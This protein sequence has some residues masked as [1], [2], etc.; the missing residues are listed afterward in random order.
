MSKPIQLIRPDKLGPGED[1]VSPPG[2][3]WHMLAEGD[4]WFSFGSLFGNSL[5]NKL[6]FDRSTLVTAT[7]KP[8]DTLR[9]MADWWRDA[10]FSALVDGGPQGQRAWK[11]DA[12][13]LSGGGND[14]IDAVSDQ[15]VD[16]Q[17][18]RRFEPGDALP[19]TPA[20]CIHADAWQR[21]EGYLRA[22]FASLS[23]FVANSAKNSAT[24]LFV[25]TYDYPTPN[26]A[27]ALP[28]GKSW[29][30]PAMEAHN[31]PPA[32]WQALSDHLIE[33]LAGVVRSLP[34]TLP[35]VHVV[36]TLGTLVR[37][38][39]G[40]TGSSNDWRNEIHPS[41]GGYAKLARKWRTAVQAL[42]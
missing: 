24:P 16:R 14:L 11:F 40:A 35:N 10:D 21:F 8:G 3:G 18:L 41:A 17:L 28:G 27:P 5:L 22:N 33:Q 25:H 34:A 7:S 37:A 23:G 20:D 1:S 32:L 6:R 4:S 2:G 12:I 42:L 31:I 38:A 30:R 19:A 39:A 15:W 29:L 13:L 36:D 26:N 9:H